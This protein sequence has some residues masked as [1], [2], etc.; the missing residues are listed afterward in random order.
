MQ[1]GPLHPPKRR[2]WL[3]EPQRMC[4]QFKAGTPTNVAE[5][6][7]EEPELFREKVQLSPVEGEVFPYGNPRLKDFIGI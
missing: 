1:A 6:Q 7:Q 5:V 2:F 3:S 4:E